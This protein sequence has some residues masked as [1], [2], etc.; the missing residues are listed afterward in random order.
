[1]TFLIARAAGRSSSAW[2]AASLLIVAAGALMGADEC[3]TVDSCPSCVADFAIYD[4][5]YEDDG[6]WEEEVTALTTMLAAYGFTYEIVDHQDLN[7]ERLGVGDG[8]LYRALIAPGGYASARDLVVTAA[9]E[10]H[11]RDFVA[12]GG[13]YLGFCAGTFWTADEVVWAEAATGDG[14]AFNHPDDYDTFPYD[15][16]LMPGQ[17]VGP[18][19]WTPWEEGLG[20]SL[21]PT[22]IDTSVEAMAAIGIPGEARFFYYGGPVFR[23]ESPPPALEV[24]ARAIPPAGLPLEALTG[25]GEPTI[26]RYAEGSGTV[27]LF[28][29]HPEMLIG[30]EADGVIMT[31]PVDEGAVSWETGGHSLEEIHLQSWNVV[32]AALQVVVGEA[33]T[34]ITGLP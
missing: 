19:G 33:V 32:H 18:F 30:S 24:W 22:A 21:Q 7:R 34:P 1:M 10:Q 17:A 15:L 2:R 29:Y 9:G 20:V 23:F 6:V 28:S 8:R 5:A 25:A 3:G 26:V 31:S 11:V 16:G 13:G 4:P 27:V 14:G 12:S